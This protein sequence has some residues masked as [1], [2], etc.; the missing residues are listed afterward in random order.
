MKSPDVSDS[1][2]VTV[3]GILDDYPEESSLKPQIIGNIECYE[4]LYAD[5]KWNMMATQLFFIHA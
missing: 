3:V 2:S 1:Y 5:L 4:R